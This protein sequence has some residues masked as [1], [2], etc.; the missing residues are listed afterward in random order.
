MWSISRRPGSSR[1]R[2]RG[3]DQGGRARAQA[4]DVEVGRRD[5]DL[6][7]TVTEIRAAVAKARYAICP[8]VIDHLWESIYYRVGYLATNPFNASTAPSHDDST[9]TRF[10][11]I[12]DHR[13]DQRRR[14]SRSSIVRCL[15]VHRP[16]C[17]QAA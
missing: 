17:R 14:R 6:D 9:P 12:D 10:A 4:H 3:D 2:P 1:P 16:I 8:E 5:V 11:R 7:T 13:C 15:T